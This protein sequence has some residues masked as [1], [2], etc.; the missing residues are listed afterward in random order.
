MGSK[1]KTILMSIRPKYANLIFSGEKKIEFRKN[2][3]PDTI[4]RVVVYETMPTGKIVGYFEVEKIEKLSPCEMW[5]K[6]SSIAGI[7]KFDFE[8]YFSDKIIA[9]GILIEKYHRFDNAIDLR[10]TKYTPPQSFKYLGYKEFNYIYSNDKIRS[11]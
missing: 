5:Q 10:T 2:R 8:K 1:T 7:D 6:Y 11:T 3:I 4:K 9:Y